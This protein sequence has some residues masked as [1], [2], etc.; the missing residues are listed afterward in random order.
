MLVYS[1]NTPDLER[2]LRDVQ[3]AAQA[4]RQELMVVEAGS[5]RDIET[6]FTTFAQR[7]AVALFIGSHP[8]FNSRRERVAALA[9]RHVLP[10]TYGLREF[11]TEIGRASCRESV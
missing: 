4:S 7:G 2:E 9:V 6:A 11:A 1:V 3:A 8:F 10:A 5:D